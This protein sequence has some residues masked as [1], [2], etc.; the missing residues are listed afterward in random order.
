MIKRSSIEQI[1]SDVSNDMMLLFYKLEHLSCHRSGSIIDCFDLID[2]HKT[3]ISQTNYQPRPGQNY[4][5]N[6]VVLL[7]G[8]IRLQSR[9]YDQQGFNFCS[10]AEKI[11]L[12]FITG[13][14]DTLKQVIS[15]YFVD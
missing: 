7:M 9:N 10:P 4:W 12:A 1:K 8:D 6:L 3:F 2:S 14:Q 11:K 15:A 5:A 13:D